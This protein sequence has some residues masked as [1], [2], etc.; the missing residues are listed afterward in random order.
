MVVPLLWITLAL[1]LGPG[2]EVLYDPNSYSMDIN[3]TVRL[4]LRHPL[5]VT[6]HTISRFISIPTWPQSIFRK[7]PWSWIGG[8]SMIP[9]KLIAQTSPSSLT[10][11]ALISW[12]PKIPRS[13]SVFLRNYFSSDHRDDQAPYN[14]DVPTDP[15]FRWNAS[16]TDLQQ[17]A[18]VFRTDILV[19]H[20][21][22]K[23]MVDYPFDRYDL[24]SLSFLLHIWFTLGMLV[25]RLLYPHFLWTQ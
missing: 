15:I 20:A 4:I 6:A 1:K 3:R 14:N 25:M 12:L 23:S 17:K 19:G 2:G 9:A 21:V 5:I 10:R 16:I 18:P 11:K 22:Y 13:N 7:L 8:F 24:K